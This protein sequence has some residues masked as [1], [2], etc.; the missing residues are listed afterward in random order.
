M[1][2]GRFLAGLIVVIVG[3]IFLGSSLGWWSSFAWE[4]L[5]RFWPVLL[6]ILGLRALIRNDGL[7]SLL[8]AVIIIAVLA[9]AILW[10]DQLGKRT[11]RY[12]FDKPFN[13]QTE[14][15]GETAN[16]VQEVTVVAGDTLVADLPLNFNITIN[17]TD[18]PSVSANLSGPKELINRL[19]LKKEGNQIFLELTGDNM[20]NFGK[21]IFNDDIT[22]TV[23]VPRAIASDLTLSG[24][25]KATVNGYASS[26]KV[27]ISGASELQ[28]VASSLTDPVVEASGAGKVALD[29]CQGTG[30]FELSGTAKVEAASCTLT[31]LTLDGSG[32][33]QFNLL[34][35]SV[36][37]LTADA[38]GASRFTLPR[39][40]GTIDQD[41]SGVA[42]I[43]FK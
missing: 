4:T 19:S 43:E 35:G 24:V 40:T 14:L 34:A 26:A 32:A 30:Q 42:Q 36:T 39:P 12:H 41:S 9:L 20:F 31:Q 38:S 21:Q 13:F 29:S 6:I 1:R 8:A 11:E 18:T 33:S 37:N 17:A 2:S 7:F 15:S 10:P 27:E 16:F 23:T 5:W 3:L 22:G 28:F 25:S